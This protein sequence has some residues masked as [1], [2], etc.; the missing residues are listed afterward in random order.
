MG[1]AKELQDNQWMYL[2]GVILV[3]PADYKL[4][5]TNQPIY[6]ALNL[7]YFTAAAWYHKVLPA[8]LLQRDLLDVLPEAENFAINTLMP[9]LAKGGFI[10]EQEKQEVAKKMSAYSSVG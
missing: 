6:S 1:L 3:S 8:D 10:S 9:A 2:N 7:P 5:K 4:Y